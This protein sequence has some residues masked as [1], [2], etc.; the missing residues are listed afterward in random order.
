[1]AIVTHPAGDAMVG[2][3][4]PT[5]GA[6]PP[7]LTPIIAA[8]AAATLVA[9]ALVRRRMAMIRERGSA[10]AAAGT[11][12]PSASRLFVPAILSWALTE[13]IAVDGLV[14]GIAHRAMA[15]FVPFA[16][17]SLVLLLLLWP[18]RAH[19]QSGGGS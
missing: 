3:S 18:R 12:A 6:P 14:L 9:V 5:R 19:F 4:V 15:Q 13:A 17:V 1:M 8:V 10:A 11:A 16:A 7:F 2:T